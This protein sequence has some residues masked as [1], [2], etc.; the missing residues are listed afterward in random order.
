MTT[1]VFETCSSGPFFILS[2]TS[3]FFADV[4]FH[5]EQGEVINKTKQNG[6]ESRDTAPLGRNLLL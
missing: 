1:G 6:L 3:N 5:S 2:F 4:K